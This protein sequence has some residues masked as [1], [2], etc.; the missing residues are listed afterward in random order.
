MTIKISSRAR[1][2]EIISNRNKMHFSAIAC[3]PGRKGEGSREGRYVYDSGGAN[4][5]CRHRRR[6]YDVR[7]LRCTLDWPGVCPRGGLSRVR[8]ARAGL[9]EVVVQLKI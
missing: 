4:S 8:C 9:P 6:D 5:S 1:H 3:A 7:S 2:P